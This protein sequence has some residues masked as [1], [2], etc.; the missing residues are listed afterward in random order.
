MCTTRPCLWLSGWDPTMAP[1]TAWVFL[2][3]RP[4]QWRAHEC[5]LRPTSPHRLEAGTGV[6]RRVLRRIA[7]TPPSPFP[8]IPGPRWVGSLPGLPA[9]RL[10]C[11]PRATCCERCLHASVRCA[12]L[13]AVSSRRSP[14]HD[15]CHTGRR[16]YPADDPCAAVHI[17]QTPSDASTGHHACKT[18]EPEMR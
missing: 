18:H 9:H 2:R 5:V 16:R 17:H 13:G 12:P 7:Q 11:L 14:M 8:P 10:A 1:P 15:P 6:L 4:C 3:S